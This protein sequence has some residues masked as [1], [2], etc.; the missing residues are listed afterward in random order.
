MDQR[1]PFFTS[2]FLFLLW[3]FSAFTVSLLLFTEGFLLRRQV[4]DV[5]SNAT[6]STRP[7]FNKVVI[8]VIDA[9][10]HDFVTFD[11]SNI[12]PE[13]YQN[14]LPIVKQLQDSGHAKVRD[15]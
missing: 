14:K 7:Q 8:M 13:A 11:E 2:Y 5:R 15:T 4:L 12:S 3:L 10:R 9:L 6:P 1:R